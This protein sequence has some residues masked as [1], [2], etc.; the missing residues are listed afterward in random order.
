MRRIGIRTEF[1]G[2][3]APR[4]LGRVVCAGLCYYM[5]CCGQS[6]SGK[7]KVA[8]PAPAAAGFA[9]RPPRIGGGGRRVPWA[10][11]PP[12]LAP[13][14][15]RSS[16][17]RFLVGGRGCAGP[18]GVPPAAAGGDAALLRSRYCAWRILSFRKRENGGCIAPALKGLLTSPPVRASKGPPLGTILTNK[19]TLIY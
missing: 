3:S 4:Q 18:R 15:A 16:A 12:P 6:H 5:W 13:W 10:R 1:E 8:P 17:R 2:A 14:V 19:K 7:E 11:P 9:S